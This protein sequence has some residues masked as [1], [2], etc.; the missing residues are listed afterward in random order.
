MTT[1]NTTISLD[2]TDLDSIATAI[3]AGLTTIQQVADYLTIDLV[4]DCLVLP[5]T[6][7]T[8][9]DGLGC[10]IECDGADTAEEAAEQYVDSGDWGDRKETCWIH[11]SVWQAGLDEDGDEAR[12]GMS[13]ETVT[14]EA[15]EPECMDGEEHVWKAPQS[16]VGGIKENPGCWGHGG[17]IVQD[18][19]CVRCGCKRIY[20]SW[21]QDPSNGQQGL[22]STEY[23]EGEYAD[24]IAELHLETAVDDLSAEEENGEYT[25]TAHDTEYTADR[26]QMIEYGREVVCGNRDAELPGS[27]VEGDDAE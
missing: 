17:G 6:P 4:D 26:D 27:E 3:K 14:L 22:T 16:I 9:A 19:V 20:D 23:A 24:E 8:A 18:S 25:Y 7:Y 12:V 1:S 10:E 21:A 2:L 15:E 13:R 5:G 11:V